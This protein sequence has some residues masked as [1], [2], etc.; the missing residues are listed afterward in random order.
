MPYSA[1]LI[2]YAFVKRGIEQGK[3]VTQMKLQ[4]LVYFAHGLHLAQY[5]Q[6]LITENIQAWKYGPVVPE[7][8]RIYNIYGSSEIVD[9]SYLGLFGRYVPDIS[10]LDERALNAIDVTWNLLRDADAVRLSNWT[11]KA[12][13]PWANHFQPNVNDL[14]IPNNEI[15]A[16][17]DT[18][19]ENQQA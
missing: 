16:Y 4:K 3:P 18:F 12:N 7:I 11:H 15:Q 10:I 17:F 19:L 6:P 13:S 14:T 5:E 9:L 1:S 2:A 8:Y